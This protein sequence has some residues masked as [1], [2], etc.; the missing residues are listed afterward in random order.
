V[1]IGIALFVAAIGIGARSAHGVASV[2]RSGLAPASLPFVALVASVS[3]SIALLFVSAGLVLYLAVVRPG[4]LAK[5][6]RYLITD[7]RV[8]IQRGPAE[9]HLDRERI[10]DVIDAPADGGRRHLFLVLDG[11]GA[12]AFAASGAFGEE[13]SGA[14]VPVLELVEDPD[15]VVELLRSQPRRSLPPLAA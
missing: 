3:L 5:D 9:L 12:R 15:S 4:R 8:L 13:P 11:K 2:L 7:R 1:L 10:V 6:T 14:L